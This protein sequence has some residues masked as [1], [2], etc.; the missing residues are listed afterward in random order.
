MNDEQPRST[1]SPL[2]GRAH[3]IAFVMAICL[4]LGLGVAVVMLLRPDS[5]GDVGPSAAAA[6]R[7]GGLP[8]F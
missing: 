4:A 8:A 3:A 5:G 2:R 6:G 7:D 1:R